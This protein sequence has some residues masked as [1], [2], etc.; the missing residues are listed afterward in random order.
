MHT[1]QISKFMFQFSQNILPTSLKGKFTANEYLHNY[2][3]RHD[4]H[5][6]SRNTAVA[7]HSIVH[8]GPKLWQTIPTN[9]KNSK[10]VHI[11]K[12]SMK[13]HILQDL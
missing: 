5:I 10:N 9:I 13:K 11:F 8:K 2:N 4:P 12:N 1:L 7:S 3:T 6:S